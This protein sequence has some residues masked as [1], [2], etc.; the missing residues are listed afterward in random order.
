MVPL[1][2]S[3]RVGQG[4]TLVHAVGRRAERLRPTAGVG[5]ISRP[6]YGRGEAGLVGQDHEL[7]AVARSLNIDRLRWVRVVAEPTTQAST[8]A[9]EDVITAGL[10][11]AARAELDALADRFLAERAVSVVA[12]RALEER[13]W[14]AP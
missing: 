7:G 1:R 6:A 8:F 2:A 9:R 14:S 10:V 11:G 13:R 3:H 4:T 5:G 12:D